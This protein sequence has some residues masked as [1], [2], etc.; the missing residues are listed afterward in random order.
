M[1]QTALQKFMMEQLLQLD[2]RFLF[3]TR[4]LG[5]APTESELSWVSLCA[6]LDC[7]NL[8]GYLERALKRA[9]ERVLR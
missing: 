8:P 1:T 5:K 2:C 4:D 3:V 7:S 6:V 9:S